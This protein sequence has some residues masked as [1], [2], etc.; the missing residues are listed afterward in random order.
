VDEIEKHEK[1]LEKTPKI[2]PFV[3]DE[4]LAEKGLRFVLIKNYMMFFI[5]NETKKD[6]KYYQVFIRTKRLAKYY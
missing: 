3:S 6:S 4:Y 5:I 1:I 2:Y